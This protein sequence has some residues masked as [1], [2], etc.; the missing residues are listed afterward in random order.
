MLLLE[1]EPK[2]FCETK[3]VIVN[4][5]QAQKS[6]SPERT[7]HSG[8]RVFVVKDNALEKGDVGIFVII[9]DAY[10]KELGNKCLF[11]HNKHINRFCLCEHPSESTFSA[12]HQPYLS[13]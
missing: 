4:D 8:N 7:F 1:I 13:R 5:F 3:K 6:S 10:I 9:G 11:S 2:S 12:D